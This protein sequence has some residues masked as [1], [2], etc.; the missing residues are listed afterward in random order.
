[1]YSFELAADTDLAANWSHSGF[2]SLLLKRPLDLNR[3][4]CGGGV[5]RH[6]Q[7]DDLNGVAEFVRPTD[8]TITH[9]GFDPTELRRF[10]R[11]AARGGADRIVP[12]GRALDFSPVWDGFDLLNDFVRWVVVQS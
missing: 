7:V 3:T 9:W 10:A 1:V 8:Q 11:H 2:V 6:V 5:L 4:S 12:I